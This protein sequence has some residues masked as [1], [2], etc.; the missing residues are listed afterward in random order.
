M[1]CSLMNGKEMVIKGP[2]SVVTVDALNTDVPANRWFFERS[3]P[4]VSDR[5]TVQRLARRRPMPR[6]C[7]FPDFHSPT[8]GSGSTTGPPTGPAPP[9]G[10][11]SNIDWPVSGSSWAS[12]GKLGGEQRGRCVS[13]PRTLSIGLLADV[14]DVHYNPSIAHN[15]QQP[16]PTLCC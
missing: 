2:K 13:I 4:H 16:L 3:S 8:H 1:A 6:Q 5:I 7:A 14:S 9:F 12:V 15:Y 10:H 11:G